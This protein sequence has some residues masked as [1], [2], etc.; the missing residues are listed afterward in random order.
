[1]KSIWKMGIKLMPGFTQNLPKGAKIIHVG[2]QKN[3]PFF[4]VE[5]DIEAEKETV[6]FFLKATGEGFNGKLAEHIGTFIIEDP[7][8][9]TGTFVGHLYKSK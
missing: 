1:M 4:W 2:V 6:A 7:A 5:V 9:P 3:L 8:H